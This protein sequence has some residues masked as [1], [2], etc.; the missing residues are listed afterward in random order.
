M[1]YKHS[2]QLFFT[3]S[4][5]LPDGKDQKPATKENTPI[6]LTY[7]ADAHEH[8][9]QPL[10]TERRFFL[11]IIRAQLQCV[12]QSRTRTKNLLAFIGQSWETACTVATEI[13]AL[14][15]NYITEPTITADEIMAIR[16]TIFLKAMRTKVEVTFEAKVG[17]SEGVTG[18][19][20]GVKPTARV[21]YGETLN[22][23]KMSEFL[24]SRIKGVK[25]FG[26][27][28]QATRELEERLI[29]RG[30]KE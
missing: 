27:W 22:E 9:P 7:I 20:L 19:S 10:T 1:T 29:A 3:P 15:V 24:E 21:C 4:S 12:H 18:L 17:S 14:D 13:K 16:S 25:G 30:K 2:L 26:V 11:Q 23:K 8:H 6:S 28:A 5:F